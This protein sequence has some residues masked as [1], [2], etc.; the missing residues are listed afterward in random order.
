MGGVV[1][2]WGETRA[3]ARNND[4]VY[5]RFQGEKTGQGRVKKKKDPP[6][7]ERGGKI[8]GEK[9]A[10]KLKTPHLASHSAGSEREKKTR[11]R[12]V[13]KPKRGTLRT[14]PWGVERPGTVSRAPHPAQ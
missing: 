1:I 7:G 3:C 12:G 14:S 6:A 2:A 11:G 9:N 13:G 4:S 8:E 5:S 10:M